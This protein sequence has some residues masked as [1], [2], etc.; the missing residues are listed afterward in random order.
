MATVATAAVRAE[1]KEEA[2][3]ELGFWGRAEPWG[4]CSSDLDARLSDHNERLRLI[5]RPFG[6]GGKVDSRPRP[7]LRPGTR[8]ARQ[9]AGPWAAVRARGPVGRGSSKQASGLKTQ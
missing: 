1:L 7:R 8:G 6:P 4:F 5:G 2:E 3:N 9:R